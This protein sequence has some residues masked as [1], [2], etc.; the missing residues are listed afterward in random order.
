M[1]TLTTADHLL[2]LQAGRGLVR[3]ILDTL[4]TNIDGK[5]ILAVLRGVEERAIQEIE[6]LQQEVSHGK[7]N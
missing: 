1:K 7:G 4:P 3:A 6:Q 5:T 2:V